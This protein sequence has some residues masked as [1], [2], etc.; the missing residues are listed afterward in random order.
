MHHWKGHTNPLPARVDPMP[1]RNHAWVYQVHSVNSDT[2]NEI[3]FQV[4]SNGGSSASIDFLVVSTAS[5]S[6]RYF[7]QA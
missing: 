5:T 3:F 7:A 1:I 4:D 2:A 6:H